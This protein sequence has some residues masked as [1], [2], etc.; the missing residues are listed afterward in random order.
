MIFYL[1]L[2]A[3]PMLFTFLFSVLPCGVASSTCTNPFLPYPV[4]LPAAFTAAAN[5]LHYFVYL[6]GTPIGN[7]VMNSITLIFFG[8]LAMLVYHILLYFRV[9][10]VSNLL[11]VIRGNVGKH[12]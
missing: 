10:I 2:A 8:Y 5:G 3:I 11:N 9:P 7:A 6:L 12:D 4:E 1:I